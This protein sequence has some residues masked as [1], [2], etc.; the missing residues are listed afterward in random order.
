ML[1]FPGLTF[2]SDGDVATIWQGTL[3]NWTQCYKT[4]YG[5]NLQMFVIS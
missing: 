3:L 4:S 2:S 1:A 5:R